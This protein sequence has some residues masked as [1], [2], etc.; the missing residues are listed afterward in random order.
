MGRWGTI[1]LCVVGACGEPHQVFDLDA[2]GGGSGSGSGSGSGDSC[3]NTQ[4]D[5]TNCGACGHDCGGAACSAG[6]CAPT[7]L[8]MAGTGGVAAT[9]PLYDDGTSVYFG[10]TGSVCN[11]GGGCTTFR[12]CNGGGC[13]MNPANLTGKGPA[14]GQA[15]TA[16]DTTAYWFYGGTGLVSCDMIGGCNANPNVVW[17]TTVT[18][19]GGTAM[20]VDATNIYWSDELNQLISSCPRTGCTTPTTIAMPPNGQQIRKGVA[21]DGTNVF[22]VTATGIYS[23]PV[24]GSATPTVVVTGLGGAAGIAL[25]ATNVYW[26]GFSGDIG[27]CPKTGCST[28][29]T[30]HQL[31]LPAANVLVDGDHLYWSQKTSMSEVGR[32]TLPACDDPVVL[33]KGKAT[34]GIAVDATNLFFTDN[35]S[36]KRVPK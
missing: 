33:A 1:L 3:V 8:A 36:L 14:T 24:A 10:S 11:V 27:R 29:T 15:F 7:L 26:A 32:C 6:L 5:P 2:Q 18:S 12:K 22:F 16:I 28:P 4:T 21:T 20:A 13:G 19:A 31:S 35:G 25:D 9:E 23:V 34:V 17:P 30:L